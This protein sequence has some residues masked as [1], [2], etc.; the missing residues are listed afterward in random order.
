L[1][2]CIPLDGTGA[3]HDSAA[4]VYQ[5]D[6][7]TDVERSHDS[8]N[9]DGTLLL[10]SPTSSPRFIP[11]TRRIHRDGSFCIVRYSRS[12]ARRL[13]LLLRTNR[14][15]GAKNF[16]TVPGRSCQAYRLWIRAEAH[17][18][19]HHT[20]LDPANSSHIICNVSLANTYQPA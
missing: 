2:D 13:S 1:S 3:M 9:L 16:G 4:C 14:T 19:T 6:S 7:G 12:T 15:E 5:H 11:H 20:I 8:T 10:P 18:L 17:R